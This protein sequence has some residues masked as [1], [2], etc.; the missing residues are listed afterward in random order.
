[1]KKI[2]LIILLIITS[3]LLT[4]SIIGLINKDKKTNIDDAN[5][6]TKI[7]IINN[8][9]EYNSE[10]NLYSLIKIENGQIKTN[11]YNI[12]TTKLGENK[13]TFTYINSNQQ[14]KFY[15]FSINVID[16]TAPLIFSQKKYYI[17]KNSDI[18][19]TKK[20]MYGDNY[21]KLVNLK[22]E[23]DYDINTIGEYNLKFIA[24]DSSN[25]ISEKEFT[26]VVVEKIEEST[27]TPTPIYLNDIINNY[28]NENTM[29]GIDVSTW[30]GDI[31][32]Q[33]VLD[34]G[35]EFVIMRIGF[36]PNHDM[37]NVLDNKFE[38][39]LENAKKVGLKVGVYFFRYAEKIS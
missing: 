23:G 38:K 36:G 4:F 30:Q 16:S 5:S 9:L 6:I 31:D 27:Y 18:D 2:I 24:S 11:D 10:I 35:I 22:V 32:Y 34:A 26:L 1:M 17:E 29:I 14:K 8:T 15:E 37:K 25:N 33:K 28:K 13:I 21:D 20:P 7:N 19:L 39:N 3:S 12:N